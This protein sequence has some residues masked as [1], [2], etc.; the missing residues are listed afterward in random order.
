MAEPILITAPTVEPVTLA[1]A[2][3]HLRIDDDNTSFDT[4]IEEMVK[5]AR[6]AAE[7]EMGRK[8]MRQTW[9]FVVD[10]F[11]CS[12]ES[13]RLP[14]DLVKPHS[15]VHIKYVDT[16]GV[17]QELD[18]AT[19]DLDAYNLPGYI[20]PATDYDWPTGVAETANAV[21]VRVMCG[22][23]ENVADVPAAIK[24]WIKLHIGTQWRY[25]ASVSPEQATEL[26][27]RFVD[28]LL[29]P[30]RVYVG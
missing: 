12:L 14:A 27:N 2:R 8:V 26:T 6:Q 11:P 28:R 17:V 15:I 23:W 4:E 22:E 19:Y 7:H 13:I 1:E 5:A 25:E 29:D 10:A 30:Y 16:S 3:A 18:S 9:D 20:F 21:S 24:R